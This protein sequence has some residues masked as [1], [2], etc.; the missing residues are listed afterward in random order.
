MVSDILSSGPDQLRNTIENKLS[1]YFNTH[2]RSEEIIGGI[3]SSVVLLPISFDDSDRPCLIFN[4]RSQS[5]RQPGDLCFPGGGMEP[6]IDLLL[7]WLLRLPFLPITRQRGWKNPGLTSRDRRLL[8]LLLATGLREGFEEMRMNPLAS[9]YLGQLPSQHLTMFRRVITP[10]VVWLSG[11][12][13]FRPNWEVEEIFS[14]PFDHLLDTSLYRRYSIEYSPGVAER[15][16][17]KSQVV[18]AFIHSIGNRQEV[19]WGA[20]YRITQVFLRIVFEFQEPV[21]NDLPEIQGTLNESYYSGT[22]RERT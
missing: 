17:R 4:K 13:M 8:S 10:L 9:E 7:A 22:G 16:G 11:L 3:T 18:P 14:I 1:G 19:L 5:V 12:Q 21:L 20:T 15:L 6:K 2:S